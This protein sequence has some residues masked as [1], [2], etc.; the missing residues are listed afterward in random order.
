MVSIIQSCMIQ[1]LHVQR[2]ARIVK[3]GYRFV[4]T[5]NGLLHVQ[6]FAAQLTHTTH[7]HTF[8]LAQDVEALRR[9]GFEVLTALK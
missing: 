6:W 4:F 1:L 3:L 2:F 8:V 7:T 9:C 5:L